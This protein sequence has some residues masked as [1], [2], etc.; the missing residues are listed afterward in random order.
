MGEKLKSTKATQTIKPFELGIWT[1][2]N[3]ISPAYLALLM[4]SDS[5][6]ILLKLLRQKKKDIEYSTIRL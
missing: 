6:K 4:F 2:R 5:M 3:V 1:T